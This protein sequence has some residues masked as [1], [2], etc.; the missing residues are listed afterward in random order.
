MKFSGRTVTAIIKYPPDKILVIKRGT[1]VF[2]GYWALPGG[3]VEPG[4]TVEH[5][6]L[7]EVKE[8]TGLD[9]EIARKIGEYHESGVSD[10]IEYDYFPT[11]FVVKPVG[12]F[13]K[14]QVEEIEEIQL[15]SLED[16]PQNMAFEHPRMI[17][18]Y[19]RFVELDQVAEAIRQCEKCR[20][21][22]TRRNAVPG[23]GPANAVILVCGQAPGRTEDQQGRP[24]VGRAGKCLEEMLRSIPLSREDIFLTSPIKCFPPKNRSPQRDEL[25]A[26][27]PYLEEQMRTIQ[28]KLI[29]ALGNYALRTLTA[30]NTGISKLH[31][32][33]LEE[34][35]TLIFPTFHPAAAIRFPKLR[36][37]ME[38]DFKKLGHLLEKRRLN[39]AAGQVNVGPDEYVQ[40]DGT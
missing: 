6:V 21:S 19:R 24:F 36:A 33:L 3:R 35:G 30:K 18:D 26:C 9:V 14:R 32:V 2:K 39:K 20:L 38:E 12:G 25:D 10:G 22:Q 31:G 11:C 1:V 16:L 34:K 7:R 8:E 5:A 15:F 13:L 27:T 40:G 23:E 37:V 17:A 4:E 29:I 28:P